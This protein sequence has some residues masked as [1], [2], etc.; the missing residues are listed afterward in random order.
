VKLCLREQT[1]LFPLRSAFSR[2]GTIAENGDGKV[3]ICAKPG[4]ESMQMRDS[5]EA[6]WSAEY[7]AEEE[8][9]RKG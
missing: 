5:H 7:A 4:S 6:I 3:V 9:F 1:A 2:N 8:G